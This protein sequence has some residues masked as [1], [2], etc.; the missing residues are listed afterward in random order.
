[1]GKLKVIITVQE[2]SDL[3]TVAAGLEAGG[4]DP[5]S[6][7]F[8]DAETG[9]PAISAVFEVPGKVTA[10]DLAGE[11]EFWFDRLDEAGI[12]GAT[13]R[14]ARF[15][16]KRS[17]GAP[18]LMVGSAAA[19]IGIFAATARGPRARAVAGLGLPDAE[20]VQ[21]ADEWLSKAEEGF[22]NAQQSLEGGDCQDAYRF[23]SFA[24]EHLAR[25]STSVA[26]I[27][28]GSRR[29][30]EARR[31]TARLR[32]AGQRYEGLRNVVEGD[33]VLQCLSGS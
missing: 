30:Q 15:G 26:S 14:A 33:F 25:A 10:D 9:R 28:R 31:L 19:V 22:D 4:G 2:R 7:P 13:V 3:D 12:V 1:M 21:I 11:E 17:V 29:E 6:D 32:E 24:N 16:A 23:L 20:H 8:T 27:P 18:L 5:V